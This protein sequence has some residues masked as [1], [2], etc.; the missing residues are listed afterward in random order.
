MQYSCLHFLH[1]SFTWMSIYSSQSHSLVHPSSWL[2]YSYF[3]VSEA[4]YMV[5]KLGG[6]GLTAACISVHD[7]NFIFTVHLQK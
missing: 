4:D 6:L 2:K 5:S 1:F 3:T 7:Y